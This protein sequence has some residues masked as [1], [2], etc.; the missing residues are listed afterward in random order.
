[1]EID[2]IGILGVPKITKT[3]QNDG[4]QS[5]Q[6]LEFLQLSIQLKK[7]NQYGNQHSR[8]FVLTNKRILLLDKMTIRR[9]VPLNYLIA[10]TLSSKSFEFILHFKDDYD[11]DDLRLYSDRRSRVIESIVK[12]FSTELQQQLPSFQVSDNSL[13]KY[14]VYKEDR[15]KKLQKLPKETPKL[16]FYKPMQEENE[17][18]NQLVRVHQTTT[19]NKLIFA[20]D[21]DLGVQLSDF[22]LVKILANGSIAQ[23]VLVENNKT[24]IQYAMKCVSKL[25]TTDQEFMD[26][27][28]FVKFTT[29]HQNPF[30][31]KL[32]YCFEYEQRWFFITQLH[33]SD[34]YKKLEIVKKMD[35]KQAQFYACEILLALEHIHQRNLIYCDLKLENILLDA[36]NHI[37]LTDFGILRNKKQ[38][39]S[40][41]YATP[42]YIAPETLLNKQNIQ[43][44]SDFWQLGIV[45]YEMIYSH[46]PFIAQENEQLF[47]YILNCNAEFPD[48]IQISNECQDLLTQ[49]LKKDPKDRLGYFGGVPEIQNH[50]WFKDVDWKLQYDKLVKP[51]EFK[52]PT[53]MQ[54]NALKRN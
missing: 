48:G 38:Y 22:K 41:V 7:T 13:K 37:Q 28:N 51:P 32:Y 4:I 31:L 16:L 14:V 33:K 39:L 50:K 24:Q 47:D 2:E 10:I 45:I 46:P 21:K 49:L 43:Y 44:Y 36:S 53:L 6:K 54:L 11:D 30:L 25:P 18:K 17:R 8:Y 35:E 3:F 12:V 42:E 19:H 29:F 9:K 23:I 5:S 26:L 20:Y 52:L 40:G 27:S 15:N 1:M 34:M